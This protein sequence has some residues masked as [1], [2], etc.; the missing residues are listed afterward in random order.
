MLTKRLV[1]MVLCASV[2]AFTSA[3][4]AQDQPAGGKP[5]V[6]TNAAQVQQLQE[7]LAKMHAEMD[8]MQ[9]SMQ[10]GNI[11]PEQLQAMQQHMSRMQSYWGQMHAGCCGMYPGGYGCGM[12]MVPPQ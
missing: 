2:L 10:A 6:Q 8:A 4:W 3:A 11:P 7:Q 12:M 9:K 1:L 5:Q